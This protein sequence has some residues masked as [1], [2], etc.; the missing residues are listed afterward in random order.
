[1]TVFAFMSADA[2]DARF[3]ASASTRNAGA[4]A[5]EPAPY[6]P[7]IRRP[8]RGLQVQDD[9]Y[10]T[11]SVFTGKGEAIP[12]LSESSRD[13]RS[14]R[15]GRGYVRE[16]GDFILSRVSERRVEKQ[17]VVET[18]GDDYIFFFGER[19]RVI[20]I[21]GQLIS[22]DDFNWKSQFWLNWESTLRG[23]RL[24][25]KNARMFLAYED[26]VIEGYP[27][28]ASVDES[29][30]QRHLMPFSMT[31]FVT[32]QVD[33]ADSGNPSYPNDDL[34]ATTI[35]DLNRQ[36]RDQA[37]AFVDN[38][39]PLEVRTKNL[40]ANG[41]FKSLGSALRQELKAVNNIANTVF[42]AIDAV[43]TGAF[44]L[45]NGRVVTTPVGVGGFAAQVGGIGFASASINENT[46]QILTA[47][48]IEVP[49][50]VQQKYFTEVVNPRGRKS[51]A[52][53]EYPLMTGR[54]GYPDIPSA[55]QQQYRLLKADRLAAD[56]ERDARLV[57]ANIDAQFKT[58]AL[59]A[60]ASTIQFSKT[61]FM[62]VRAASNIV[63]NIANSDDPGAAAGLFV[64]NA[65]TGAGLV[66]GRQRFVHPSAAEGGFTLRGGGSVAADTDPNVPQA[67][68]GPSGLARF[69]DPANAGVVQD[70]SG[71]SRFRSEPAAPDLARYPDN[72]GAFNAGD[73]LDQ[74]RSGGGVLPE[75]S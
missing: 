26:V 73:F 71:V 23:T 28:E 33:F 62:M 32:N 30:E 47:R 21:T 22:S 5:G 63:N 65:L 44:S 9:T 53:D 25:Q 15:G 29:A 27:L 69:R 58:D 45:L 70:Q 1:M 19:P 37:N 11:F 74:V 43:R 50:L 35:Q 36:L 41:G 13:P 2:F 3:L 64:A 51:D 20:Q 66:A 18:F 38:A 57:K 59:R 8:H 56:A 48:G 31:M 40:R 12:L 42:G 60:V 39:I 75:G 67:P 52:L 54:H 7:A 55:L 46:R 49:V 16:Y 10:A 72:V 68:A 6:R 24:V 61:G 17:Q 34:G 14:D 4:T